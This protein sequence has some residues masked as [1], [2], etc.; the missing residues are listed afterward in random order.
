MEKKK[1]TIKDIEKC[2]NELGFE[3]IERYVYNTKTKQYET[4][5]MSHFN[6][7]PTYVYI[8]NNIRKF[9]ALVTIKNEE[10]IIEKL[11]AS[12][13]WTDILDDTLQKEDV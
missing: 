2:L 9:V 12:A 6:V 11:N 3:W 1:F 8:K 5:R 10:F 13:L 4:A 7:N